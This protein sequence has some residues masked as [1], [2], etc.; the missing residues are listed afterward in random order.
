[1]VQHARL[2]LFAI[3]KDLFPKSKVIRCRAFWQSQLE[4]TFELLVAIVAV[5]TV[6]K[7]A[8]A[9]AIDPR[10]SFDAEKGQLIFVTDLQR[11]SV[12]PSA[13]PAPCLRLPSLVRA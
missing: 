5:H 12:S 13:R 6:Q 1:M 11:S 2:P 8:R 9:D 7:H 4:S 10:R 3:D